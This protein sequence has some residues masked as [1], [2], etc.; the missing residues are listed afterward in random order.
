MEIKAS[1]YGQRHRSKVRGLRFDI[2]KQLLVPEKEIAIPHIHEKQP[3][4][5]SCVTFWDW[6]M[7][8]SYTS[9]AIESKRTVKLLEIDERNFKVI[10]AGVTNSC[11]VRN[12]H[13]SVK[14]E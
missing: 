12:H 3:W 9:K 5:G 13:E 10:E 7:S 8:L 4:R 2:S 1:V 14:C 11:L 6:N